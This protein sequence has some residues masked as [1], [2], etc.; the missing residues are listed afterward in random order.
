MHL[1]YTLRYTPPGFAQACTSAPICV[2]VQ[3]AATHPA[4]TQSTAFLSFERQSNP[5]VATRNAWTAP[6]HLEEQLDNLHRPRLH[7]QDP[8]CEGNVGTITAQRH[9]Q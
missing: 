4:P 2:W 8:A 9:R 7:G 3:R 1:G 5:P 6:S